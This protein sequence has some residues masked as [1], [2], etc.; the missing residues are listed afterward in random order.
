MAPVSGEEMRAIVPSPPSNCDT[1]NNSSGDED[2]APVENP[3]RKLQ[4]RI[5]HDPLS[6]TLADFEAGKGAG[7]NERLIVDRVLLE[8]VERLR[9]GLGSGGAQVAARATQKHQSAVD[10][11][12]KLRTA[13]LQ[14]VDK[15]TSDEYLEELSKQKEGSVRQG[16]VFNNIDAYFDHASASLREYVKLRKAG[17]LRQYGSLMT[18]T[19]QQEQEMLETISWDTVSQQVEVHIT[20]IRGLRDKVPAGE[21][22]VLLSKYDRL[23]G[24]PFRWSLRDFSSSHPPPCPLHPG[25]PTAPAQ[26]RECEVCQGWI[27]CTTPVHHD[28]GVFSL[29]IM[30]DTSVFTFLPPRKTIKPYAVFVFE[31][32]RLPAH[33]SHRFTALVSAVAGRPN[34]KPRRPSRPP[35]ANRGEKTDLETP[36]T[37]GWG[38]FPVINGRFTVIKGKFKTPILR[39]FLDHRVEHHSEMQRRLTEDL[40]HWVGNL[41]FEVVPFPRSAEG[42]SEFDIDCALSA[43]K[44]GLDALTDDARQRRLSLSQTAAA[45]NKPKRR[46]SSG[47]ELLE[48]ATLG[49]ASL[50]LQDI[51]SSVGGTKTE[52]YQSRQRVLG[53]GS[54]GGGAGVVAK[55]VSSIRRALGSMQTLGKLKPPSQEQQGYGGGRGP[56]DLPL[57]SKDDVREQW[58][59]D[60]SNAASRFDSDEDDVS[61]S[62]DL[63]DQEEG[64]ILFE[65]MDKDHSGGLS[66]SE[67]QQFLV[68]FPEV[69]TKLGVA[70]VV[71][72]IDLMDTDADGVIDVDEFSQVWAGFTSGAAEL[73]QAKEEARVQEKVSQR[74]S[75]RPKVSPKA[76]AQRRSVFGVA[77]LKISRQEEAASLF[78]RIK[79]LSKQRGTMRKRKKKRIATERTERWAQYTPSVNSGCGL[80]E[81]PQWYLQLE[82]CWRGVRDELD[83]TTPWKR[84]F[85]YTLTV[86]V[87]CL[88]GHFFLRGIGVYAATMAI[89]LPTARVEPSWYGLHVDYDSNHTTALQELFV[90]LS[91]M[92]IG[93]AAVILLIIGGMAVKVATNSLPQQVSKFVYCLALAYLVFPWLHVVI[94][95]QIEP[96]K[97]AGSVHQSDL[98]RLQAFYNK[99]QYEQFFGAATF[100][101]LY[102]NLCGLMSVVI[103]LYTMHVHLNGILQDCFWRINLCD[104]RT[105]FVP[106]DLEVSKRE[107][108][109]VVRKAEMWRGMTGERRKTAVSLIVTT[110]EGDPDYLSKQLHVEIYRLEPHVVVCTKHTGIRRHSLTE[111]G[112][113]ATSEALHLSR[114]LR[115]SG[116]QRC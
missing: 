53:W 23:S 82:Y 80:D 79:E 17:I 63:E 38:A 87:F 42:R 8:D 43:K 16:I 107:L 14:R 54:G 89:G 47:T 88:Y 39:G 58:D 3:L 106:L 48:A 61:S 4:E 113:Q 66:K 51:P 102:L 115:A 15:R 101:I 96:D 28:G 24:A 34:A 74:R 70:D 69:K 112:R 105:F 49:G 55:G 18:S 57:R 67:I 73:L 76:F 31:L 50:A 81:G 99:N 21:Y 44:L 91:G 37:V 22:V 97:D 36:K 35:S 62:S 86:F 103:Y 90:L 30:F 94:D 33:H 72:F 111:R 45:L 100:T 116:R 110:D 29:D 27:G 13:A 32:V 68:D 104:T 5:L 95:S 6:S 2:P 85:Y 52:A 108:E 20:G 25:G 71:E 26:N 46:R 41:Y 77:P 56:L 84:Q 7:D 9:R 109:Y 98:L 12:D 1:E 11:I 60:D 78:S 114:I 83:L 92:A 93:V 59:D 40:E 65:L 10:G 75:P 19:L 64:K